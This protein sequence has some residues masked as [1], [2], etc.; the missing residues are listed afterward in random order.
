M[1]EGN[2]VVVIA[3]SQD[4]LKQCVLRLVFKKH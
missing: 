4:G 2:L 1:A 3:V